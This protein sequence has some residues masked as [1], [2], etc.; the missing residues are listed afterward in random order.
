MAVTPEDELL[1]AKDR[2]K[3]NRE[4]DFRQ[5]TRGAYYA[6]FHALQNLVA[7]Q[8]AVLKFDGGEHEHVIA[9][10]KHSRDMKIRSLGFMLHECRGRRVDADYHMERD[11]TRETA[12][13]QIDCVE[14]IFA[15]MSE[16]GRGELIRVAP[17][18][19]ER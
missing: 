15:R 1:D 6:A 12:E 4:I 8:V 3:G 18:K 11:F 9:N 14:R 10:L 5:A 2:L 7:Q 16:I 19:S 17:T 13:L